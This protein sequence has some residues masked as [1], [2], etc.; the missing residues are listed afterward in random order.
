MTTTT[1]HAAVMILTASLVAGSR[2]AGWQGMSAETLRVRGE[3]R[4]EGG[5]PLA[6][7]RL[8]TDALRGPNGNPFSGQRVFNVRTNGKGEWSLLGLT[9]GLWV[10]EISASDHW[11]HVV[12]VP[13]YMMAKPEPVPWETTL[14]LMP[15]DMVKPGGSNPDS[16]IGHLRDA[17]DAALGGNRRVA[18][19]ALMKL[20]ELSLDAPGLCAAGDIAMLIREPVIARRFFDAAAVADPKGYR[21]QLGIASASMLLMDFDRAIKG[22]D[23][24]RTGTNEQRLQ[25]MLSNAVRE[26]QQIRTIGKF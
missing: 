6:G 24:A 9:R 1:R 23:V 13:I 21:P 25:K 26:I 15:H 4:T 5:G 7:A 10:F 18:Q 8:K 17:A 2:L 14:S 16:A 22:Y 3:I 11:P 20:V 19:E 12:V